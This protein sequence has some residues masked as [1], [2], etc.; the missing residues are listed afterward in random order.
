MRAWRTAHAC[1]GALG[2]FHHPPLRWSAT[3]DAPGRP[4]APAVALQPLGRL[5]LLPPLPQPQVLHCCRTAAGLH[6]AASLAAQVSTWHPGPPLQGGFVGI[7]GSGA[8]RA[9]QQCIRVQ[10]GGGAAADSSGRPTDESPPLRRALSCA[11]RRAAQHSDWD[12]LQAQMA[13]HL[14][15][16]CHASSLRLSIGRGKKRQVIL[17]SQRAGPLMRRD[18]CGVAGP[19]P[20]ATRL[21]PAARR[22]V[23]LA[24]PPD[25]S[26]AL[27][28]VA[29]PSFKA[30]HPC[31]R[32]AQLRLPACGNSSGGPGRQ[33][34][35]S[36]WGREVR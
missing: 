31:K 9:Q 6:P 29:G 34:V 32:A 28:V 16:A 2:A 36:P 26:A 3:A 35:L 22:L 17:T 15:A 24:T 4:S 8:L 33:Q 10:C 25:T 12:A 5:L 1:A 23:Q 14:S 21:R 19:Q 20:P 27:T 11:G 13:A 7:Q 18:A 30:V